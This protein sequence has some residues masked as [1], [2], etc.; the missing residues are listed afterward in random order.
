MQRVFIGFLMFL[1]CTGFV[2][3]ADGDKIHELNNSVTVYRESAN[4]IPR[5]IEGTLLEKVAK[6]NEVDAV[7]EYFTKYKDAYRMVAPAQ[8]IRAKDVNVDELG[9]R[10]LRMQQ[11]YQGLDVIGGD[12]SAHFS[13]DG[14]LR[15]VNGLYHPIKDL[16]ITPVVIA[17]DAVTRAKNDL[18]VDFGE[19]TPGNV[20]L[21]VFPFEKETYLCWRLFLYSDVPMGRWEY[22]IDA[23]TGDIIFKAN[24][25]M[26]AE[27]VGSG[28]GVMGNSYNHIDTWDTGSIFEM[29]DYTRRA[30]NNIHGHDGQMGSSSVIQTYLASSSLP[31]SIATDADNVWGGTNYAPAVD[32]H[33]YSVLFY[34]WVLREY[35]RNS[36]DD[37]GATMT[38]SVNY[39]AEGDN[40]AYWN[41]SQIV[42]W[43]WSTGWRSLAG[44]PDVIAHE[45]GH[46][47]TET[48]SGLVYQLESG[49]LNESF[50]D[51]IGA[52]F[53]FAHDTLDTP[54]WLMGENGTISGGG[55]RDMENPHNKS[56]P[57]Y[58][59]TSD[60]YWYDVVGCTPSYFND[61]CGVHT[62]SGVGNK[63]FSLLSDGG[64]HHGITVNG[65]GV[66]TAMMIAF[67]ANA[68]YW[69]S[70]I[71]YHDAAIGTISA[72]HDL[73]PSGAWE[74]QVAQAWNAVGVSTPTPSL[75]FTFPN[76]IPNTTTPNVEETFEVV[77][78]GTLGGVPVSGSG[79]IYISVN[80]RVYQN[81]PMTETTPNNYIATLPA[82]ICGDVIEFYFSAD[83]TDPSITIYDGSLL[84]PYAASPATAVTTAFQDDFESDLGWT[85][86][87]GSW[88]RGVPSGGSGDHGGPDPTS[89]NVGSSVL[90]YNL[91][92][93][94][95]NS[96]PEYHAT[97]P[98]I[99]C[100]D[101]NTVSLKFWRWL[102]VEQSVYDHA[103]IRVS[104]DGSVWSTIWQNGGTIDDN[105]W[106]EYEYDISTIAANEPTVYIRFTLG[107]T[108]GGWTYC[109][110]NIDDLRVSGS[111]CTSGATLE[112]TTTSLPDWSTGVTY[113]EQLTATGGNG[114]VI[115]TDKNNDLSGS[116][117]SLSTTGLLS[118]IVTTAQPISFTA[119]VTDDVG[120]DEQ[121]LSF[122]VNAAP[123]IQTTT[124]PDWTAGE[125]YSQQTS[126]SGGTGALNFT[127]KNGD[128]SGTGLSL[129]ANG[130]LSGT[131]VNGVVSFTLRVVDNVGAANE[132]LLT[133]NVNPAIT[134]DPASLP[135]WTEGVAYSQQLTASGGTG[136]LIFSDMNGDLASSGLS[137][138][139]TGL[140]S[141]MPLAGTYN[142]TCQVTDA[143]GAVSTESMS[144]LINDPLEIV[145]TSF[146]DW[147]EG[148][149]INMQIARI[150][151]T[152]NVSYLDKFDELAG[153]GL[154]LTA[155]G[156][157]T[158]SVSDSGTFTFT[159]VATDDIGAVDE[160]LLSIHVNKAVQIMTTTVPNAEQ[161]ISYLYQIEVTGGSQAIYWADKNGDLAGTGLSINE[162]GELTGIPQVL[163]DHTFTVQ[164][165]DVPG[166]MDEQLLTVSINLPYLC[167]D[168][169]GTGEIDIADLVYIVAYMFG[170]P[171]G[172]Q[173]DI[174]ASIDIDASGEIDIADLVYLV[175]FMFAS[176]PDPLC[177]TILAK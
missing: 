71:D 118:G 121:L 84:D 141:G 94:Y 91:S 128:L 133:F 40:N 120:T 159:A 66:D 112:I 21:V 144:L 39:S 177:G 137:I 114:T 35:N 23:K 147:T 64:T 3:A 72:A 161:G 157:L 171:P 115:W 32:G 74:W 46:A 102:G 63:W 85:F 168:A 156:L 59:G 20:E 77:V 125:F 134:V 29:R 49:A 48:T 25:I 54:D 170:T 34:D 150:G 7:L 44:C 78:S 172:P 169:D 37:N 111:E 100:S 62:N 24:R 56:D 105:S 11:V 131:P 89:G 145:T 176:G 139:T 14:D 163:G 27:A 166:S 92:G 51:M 50:S 41:G 55:F 97:S 124:L 130:L 98:A 82:R 19:G 135:N 173:P 36:Y 90:G 75:A 122:T 5:Y 106:T 99:D 80:N 67:R 113:S 87:G 132:Q 68:I 88:G 61:W 127:D 52:A 138:S 149:P 174:M 45:W 57:D 60:P 95:T 2:Y 140:L 143:I 151:G 152:N 108:D 104:T 153:S 167:G 4:G 1:L 160:Q 9:M 13:N 93:G 33:M 126:A 18:L 65:L 58:Y 22:F 76:G 8:E 148:L 123:Q 28:T 15:T 31:G 175:D 69:T 154:S 12:M 146:Q 103:Y 53:E 79:Q 17:A 129:T 158:G 109:G 16:D 164:A 142:F 165:L 6:G 83:M 162:T 81:F 101:L 96:M 42:V 10:H 43:S 155:T 119:L 30:N 107:T 136:G 110:W 117:L 38:T 73:D 86:S 70:S 47:I 116:G 26:D